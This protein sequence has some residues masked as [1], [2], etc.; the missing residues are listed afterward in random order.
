MKLTV[1]L[2]TGVAHPPHH[3][4]IHV[5]TTHSVDEKYAINAITSMHAYL[6]DESLVY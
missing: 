4:E 1:K 5:N 3:N 2:Y 6:V